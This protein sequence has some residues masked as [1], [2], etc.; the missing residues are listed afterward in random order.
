M[1]CA[2]PEIEGVFIPVDRPTKTYKED[3]SWETRDLLSELR[4]A[5]YDFRYEDASEIWEE[6]NEELLFEYEQVDAPEDQPENQEGLMWIRITDASS[7]Y[8]WQ[9]PSEK[10]EGEIVALVYP[11]CD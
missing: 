9:V 11:N 4:S 1:F 5:N 3:G 6:L 7:D 10:L 8:E 2:H